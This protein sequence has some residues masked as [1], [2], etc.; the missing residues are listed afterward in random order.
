MRR[1]VAVGLASFLLS[2][3]LWAGVTPRGTEFRVNT[4]TTGSQSGSSVAS[5]AAG[6]FVVVWASS[7]G[8]GDGIFGRRFDSTGAPLGPEF[9]VNTDTTSYQD[10]PAVASD[11]H[12]NFVVVW[13]SWYADGHL[14]GIAGR[15]FDRTGAPRDPDFQV[16]TH[17]TSYQERPKVASDAEGN[18]VVVWQS[19]D[20][21]GSGWGGFGQFFDRTGG[22]RGSE[23]QVNTFTI[24]TQAPTSVALEPNGEAVIVWTSFGQDG[25]PS[26][27][28]GR[29]FDDRGTPRGP[30]FQVD[31]HTISYQEA[32]SVAT[33]AD[34]N[35]VVAWQSWDQDGSY[36]GIFGRKFDHTGAAMGPE[37]PINTYTGNHQASANVV[38]DPTGSFVVAW[39]TYWQDGDSWGVCGQR[40]DSTGAP[41]GSE[42]PVN[43]YTAGPQGPPAIASDSGGNFV[44]T[45]NSSDGSDSGVFGQRF[46]GRLPELTAPIDGDTLDCSDPLM[47]RPTI[48]WD[49]DGYDRF[50]VYI[51][52]HAGFDAGYQV[53]SGDTLLRETSWTPPAKKWRKACANA[54]ALHPVNPV[55]YVKVYGVD[56]SLPKKNP[57]RKVYSEIVQVT[58]QQ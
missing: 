11:A 38:S 26:G 8:S 27:V 42:I 37:I 35:F 22:R 32:P 21:D 12:G 31:T 57:A 58:V 56:S 19:L 28:F 33:D 14:S 48:S 5:D 24:S 52:W 15:R 6:N 10:Y 46:Y 51:G 7:D 20:Q 45:W 40:F 55:L 30:E 53:N 3:T 49:D 41:T 4:Y 43:T 25:S 29:L 13:Q 44:V 17:T 9:Q 47:S 1:F 36:W 34:G 2:G 23:F 18:F 50:R 54:L 39:S 16:N